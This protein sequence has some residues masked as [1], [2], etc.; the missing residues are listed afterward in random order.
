MN[1][2]ACVLFLLLGFAFPSRPRS[3]AGLSATYPVVTSYEVRPGVL[4]IPRYTADGQVC[5]MS[6]ARQHTT[7]SGVYLDSVISDKLAIDISDELV[8][9]AARGHELHDAPDRLEQL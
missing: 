8:P 6:F 7:R 1:R 4:M 2:A 9:P 5:E 3:P